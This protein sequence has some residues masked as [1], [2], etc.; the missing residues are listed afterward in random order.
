MIVFPYTLHWGFKTGWA[1]QQAVNFA[2]PWWLA[3]GILAPFCQCTREFK[4]DERSVRIYLE[5]IILVCR[6]PLWK[7][8]CASDWSGMLPFLRDD[9]LV[10]HA[11]LL[12]EVIKSITLQ[13]F[14]TI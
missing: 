12:P 8:Y 3:G 4:C 10:I 1:V 13:V 14:F 7:S 9:P 5:K 11:G 2:D 6:E